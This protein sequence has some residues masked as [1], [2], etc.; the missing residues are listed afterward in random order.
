VSNDK[1]FNILKESGNDLVKL[2]NIQEFLGIVEE[3]A[4]LD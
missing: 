2:I 1:H 4:R 3:L